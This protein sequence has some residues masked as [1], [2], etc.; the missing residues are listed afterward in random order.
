M[1]DTGISLE[2]K[3]S[4]DA[5]LPIIGIQIL[6][7]VIPEVANFEYQD[8]GRTLVY[9]RG[10]KML[11]LDLGTI[12]STVTIRTTILITK[13]ESLG[14]TDHPRRDARVEERIR[15]IASTEGFNFTWDANRSLREAKMAVNITKIGLSPIKRLSGVVRQI[16]EEIERN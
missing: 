15:K 9:S 14:G 2:S 3:D 13:D 7:D 4:P 8:F 16:W 1:L 11:R 12:H 10:N 5:Y 6:E